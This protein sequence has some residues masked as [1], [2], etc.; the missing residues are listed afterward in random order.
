MNLEIAPLGIAPTAANYA[1]AIL[2]AGPHRLL[3][4]SGIAPIN[5]AGL[6]PDSI[7]D[8]AEVVW[9]NLLA[10]IHEA[11]MRVTDIVSL[12]TYVVASQ[13]IGAAL[14]ARDRALGGH[15]AASTLVAVPQLARP[16]WLIEIALVAAN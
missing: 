11:K 7:E 1:H 9:V 10:I 14:V 16:E 3:H 2:S 12:T 8:Q 6:V 4:T 5:S 15:R 13:P